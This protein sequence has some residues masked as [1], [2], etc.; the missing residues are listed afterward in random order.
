MVNAGHETNL[1]LF[2]IS[3]SR[4]LEFVF[5]IALGISHV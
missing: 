5:L 2:A 1:Y 3:Y 4:L